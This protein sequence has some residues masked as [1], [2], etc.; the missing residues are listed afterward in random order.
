MVQATVS[1]EG[2]GIMQRTKLGRSVGGTGLFRGRYVGT[3]LCGAVVLGATISQEKSMLDRVN[4]R[5]LDGIKFGGLVG[6]KGILVATILQMNLPN[7]R[8]A[9]GSA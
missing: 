3:G 5:R 4:V 1:I 9:A 8:S 6:G 7:S 2:Y